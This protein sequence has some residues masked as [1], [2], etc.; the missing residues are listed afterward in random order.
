M[1]AKMQDPDSQIR[2]EI[3]TR[4]ARIL[5]PSIAR[6]RLDAHKHGGPSGS[7]SPTTDIDNPEP[8]ETKDNE[9]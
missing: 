2:T 3:L 7:A 6:S 8:L 4:L 5:A 9:L 1:A